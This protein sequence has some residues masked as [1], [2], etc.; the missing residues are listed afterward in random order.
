VSDLPAPE[1]TRAFP[2]PADD[3]RGF[4]DQ[5][6]GLPVVPDGAQPGPEEPIRR[7]QFRSLDGALQNGELMAEREDLELKRGFGR[8]RKRKPRE[9]IIG[10]RKGIEGETATPRLS[11]RSDFT[12]TTFT[13]IETIRRPLK[14]LAISALATK[15]R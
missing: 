11:I 2:V 15:I 6:A 14:F 3:G 10:G 8:K 13:R 4:D 5:D 7:S 12:K 1:Q 9:P